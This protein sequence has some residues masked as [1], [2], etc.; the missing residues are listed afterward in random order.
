MWLSLLI[1][2]NQFGPLLAVVRVKPHCSF[3]HPVV[4]ISFHS[5][6]RFSKTALARSWTSQSTDWLTC[7][8]LWFSIW[9]SRYDSDGILT[10]IES[11]EDWYLF[12]KSAGLDIVYISPMPK[13]STYSPPGEQHTAFMQWAIAQGVQVNG[14]EPARIPG[15]GLGM[16]AIRDIQVRNLAIHIISPYSLARAY[17]YRRKMRQWLKCQ[18]QPC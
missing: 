16:I 3:L 15:R 4:D 7:L 2:Q 14:V 8:T 12:S 1:G 13:M 9:F 5:W 17:I 18:Y 6:H 10:Q 11:Q